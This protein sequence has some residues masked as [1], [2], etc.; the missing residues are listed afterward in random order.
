MPRNFI[1]NRSRASLVRIGASIAL[2]LG[3]GVAL[4]ADPSAGAR[5][6]I[7][8]PSRP[9]SESL[10]SI[11]GQTGVSVLFDPGVVLGRMSHAVSGQLSAVEAIVRALDGTGLT[12]QVMADGSIVIRASAPADVSPQAVLRVQTAH[13]AGDAGGAG[14]D[15]HDARLAQAS[16]SGAS[17]SAPSSAG[18]AGG[19]PQELQRVEVTG[20][21]LKRI[22]ADGPMPVNVYTRADIDKSGQPTLERFLST[23]NEASMSPGEGGLG[24]TT[25][26]GSV[27]LRGLPLGSTLVLINGRRVQAVGSSSANFFNLNLIPM[28]AVERVEVVP[29]GSS[30][31][32]GGDALAGVVNVILK[33][34]IDGVAFDARA[35]TARG[36]SDGSVSLATG[37]RDEGGSFLLLGSY[38]KTTPLTMAERG[39]FVDG[40]YRRYGGVDARARSCT[41]GTVSSTTSANLPGL[42]STF[43]AIPVTQAGQTPSIGSFAAGQANLC[44]SLANGNG[45]AL[46]YGTEDFAVHASAD[47]RITDLWSGFG[48]LTFTSDRLRAEQSGLQLNNVLVPATNPYNPFGVAVRVTSRLGLQNGAEGFIRNTDFTRALFGTH[49]DLGAGWELEATVSTTRDD[50]ERRLVNN[51]VNTAARTAA[52]GASTTAAALNPFTSG[53]AASDDVLRSIWSDT[54]RESHGRKDQGSAFLRGSLLKLP[55][56]SV[57]VIVGTE[58]AH[59]RYQT[60]TPGGNHVLDGR[61]SQAVYGELRVPLMRAGDSAGQGWELAA[62]TTA[63]RRDRYSDFGGANTYQA[64]LEVRPVRTVLMRASMATSFKPPTLLETSVDDTSLTSDVYGL[65]DPANGG[66]PI[67][68]A[69]VLRTT[70]HN[71]TPETGRAYSLGAVWEPDSAAGTRFG[72]TAWR[73]KIDRL[74]SLLWPQVTLDYESLF[75]GFVTRGPSVNGAPGAVTRVLYAEV[76]FGGLETSGVDLEMA[77]SW[78]AAGGKFTVAASATR[79][80]KYD[81]AVAPGAPVED[82]LGRRA[83]DYWAPKWKGRLS[84][85]FDEAAWSLGLTSRYLGSYLDTGTSQRELGN[86]WLHDLAGSLD[87]KRLGWRLNAV[88][89]AKLSVG[90]VNVLNRQP[91][92]VETS[93]YYDI[94]QADWRG[95]YANVRLALNW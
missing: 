93:P 22:D 32:Y 66:A 62:L 70:N 46:V 19:Q 72:A 73:V 41:P 64:G 30:A 63:A 49:G 7:D 61:S 6:R 65:V 67:L 15:L 36:T 3:Q 95:R 11:A 92:F 38:S 56:G 69:E 91:Q 35:G 10:R 82:R 75:P 53:S 12:A 55:A 33:K 60:D 86:F 78:K 58:I 51:T 29:V 21:R 54:V 83:L 5:Y 77:H 68:G 27:Q 2:V 74:I 47:H 94:T 48:E 31:V 45:T 57:D 23:L 14:A 52:L 16:S 71:L 37:R 79:T 87:L 9:L 39:F 89:S 84:V 59:D 40:D 34:S 43:A 76:N 8:Q 85:G 28:A 1:G 17:V 50:G 26:Q 4:A 81:V 88:S 44:N 18:L 25:G 42:N 24:A 90:I 80:T 13:V 20:S